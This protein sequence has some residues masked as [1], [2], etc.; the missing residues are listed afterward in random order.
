MEDRVPIVKP[1]PHI[2]GLWSLFGLFCFRVGAQ[3]LQKF[4]PVAF[5]PPFEDWHSGTLPYPVLV[6]FQIIFITL[7]LFAIREVSRPDAKPDPKKGKHF[8]IVGGLYFFI[9]LVRLVGG[10]T[11]ASSM[12]WFTVRLPTVFHLVLAS[13]ILLYGH[14][15]WRGDREFK[16]GEH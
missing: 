1:K 4:F 11:F 16:V 10:Y 9:M 13:F 15:H 12:P 7:C 6:G 14:F 8:L 2:A 3:L 5:L